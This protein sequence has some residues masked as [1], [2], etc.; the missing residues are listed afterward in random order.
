MGGAQCHGAGSVGIKRAR[1]AHHPRRTVSKH[2]TQALG[3][4]RFDF[5]GLI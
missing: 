2:G 3:L 5:S 4:I 1:H